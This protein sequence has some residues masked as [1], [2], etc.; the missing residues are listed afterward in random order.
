MLVVSGINRLMPDTTN[1]G[2]DSFAFAS[3]LFLDDLDA[4]QR[5][6]R[7]AGAARIALGDR[8][9]HIHALDHLTEDRV[10]AVQ[11]R[12]RDVG[13]EKLTAVGVWA[14]VGHRQNAGAGVLQ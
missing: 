11:P 8:I 4:D 9:D 6:A 1:A 13:D 5:L 14:G 3:A 10:L 2:F 7:L 12:S